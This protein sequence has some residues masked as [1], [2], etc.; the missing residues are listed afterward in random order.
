[1]K[2]TKFNV[3]KKI[4]ASASMLLVSAVMLS[5]AT[6]AWFSMNKEVTVTGMSITAKSD[7]TFLLVKAGQQ[8][9]A[10]IKADK[11]TTDSALTSSAVLYPTAHDAITAAS[12]GYSA[13][14][15]ADST[16]TTDK[17]IWYYRYSSDPADY[18]GTS[19]SNIT[20]V[21]TANFANYVLVNEFSLATAD[22][23][24]ELENLRVKSCTITTTGDQAVKVLVA[25]ANGC[26]EFDASTGADISASS[27]ALQSAN[28]TSSA[29]STV[30]VYVYWD[31]ND[32]D[33]YTNGVADLTNTSVDVVLTGDIVPAS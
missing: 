29:A 13:I 11:L 32:T 14:E 4:M 15:A 10:D 27:T 21:P 17:D 23:S 33:V 12:T 1:M 26:Q 8:T 9:V 28:V 20:Y 5:S 31:G 2:N 18:M 19:P 7:S 3:Q 22:G 16:N 6:Y 30:K 24:N 25:G